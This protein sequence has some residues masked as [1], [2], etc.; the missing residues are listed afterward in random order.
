MA[1]VSVLP[2][3]NGLTHSASLT[4]REYTVE[5]IAEVSSLSTGPKAIRD[6]LAAQGFTAGSYYRYPLGSPTE[7]DYASYLQRVSIAHSSAGG[8]QYRV[9][10]EYRPVDI[11]GDGPAQGGGVTNWIMAPTLAPPTL[12]WASEDV[13]FACTHD[14]AGEP[15]LNAAGDPFDPPITIFLPTPIANVART[16]AAFKPIWITTYKGTVNHA[17]WMGFPAE[18]VLCKDIT[19]DRVHDPDHG[20]LWTVNYTFAF[21]PSVLGSDDETVIIAGWDTQVLNA[22]KR[23]KVSGV[24]EVIIIN[25]APVSDPVPLQLDGTYD[26]D[27][28]PKYLRFAV[29]PK[30]D[31]SYFN[32]P[33]NLFDSA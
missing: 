23:E 24:R 26:P 16:E 2:K 27:G 28:D 8:L 22:G 3:K 29:Y 20:Y 31:F 10:L 5:L 1:I 25:G 17:A 9:T 21:R 6:W 32:F 4:G 11:A 19:A 33:P 12:R 15:I 13:E 14:R 7:I 18:S 30:K